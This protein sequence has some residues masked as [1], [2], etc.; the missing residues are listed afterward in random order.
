MS[1]DTVQIELNFAAGITGNDHR[2]IPRFSF[3]GVKPLFNS[4]Q[5]T[6]MTRGSTYV[7][8]RYRRFGGEDDLEREISRLQTA[9]QLY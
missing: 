6:F 2:I 1:N 5:C 8:P 4:N 7:V 9:R 3:S